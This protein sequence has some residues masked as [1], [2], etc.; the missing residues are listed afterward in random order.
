MAYTI[1]LSRRA[2]ADVDAIVEYI[3]ADSAQNATRWRRQLFDK[4]ETLHLF[5]RGCAMASE[6]EYCPFEVRQT[7]IGNYRV[8]FTVVEDRSLV[9]V[10]T[11][12]HG[13]RRFIPGWQLI[14]TARD[15][16]DGESDADGKDS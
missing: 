11:V 9:Y 13:A 12:R 1:E 4:I 14:E 10:L 3:Q 8:L 6:D 5:P 7:V 2:Y 16:L 15:A